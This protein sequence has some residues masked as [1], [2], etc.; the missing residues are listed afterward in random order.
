MFFRLLSLGLIPVAFS[1]SQ[2]AAPDYQERARAIALDLVS[3]HFDKVV[4]Q[5]DERVAQALPVDKLAKSW[6][7]ILEKTGDYVSI[8]KV[9]SEEKQGYQVVYVTCAFQKRRQDIIVVYDAQGRGV[10][11]CQ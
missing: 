8:E 3:R 7:A 9:R 10:G 1:M 11:P 6:E 2:L 4:S 5:F